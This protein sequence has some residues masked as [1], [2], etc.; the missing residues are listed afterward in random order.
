MTAD[1]F[2]TL[3]YGYNMN[4]NEN[5]KPRGDCEMMTKYSAILFV[6]V[7]EYTCIVEFM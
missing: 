2:I 7:G 1:L 4:I 6:N 3:I 5:V